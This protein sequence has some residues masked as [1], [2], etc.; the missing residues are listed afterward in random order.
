MADLY[1]ERLLD[2]LRRAEEH[3][4]SALWGGWTDKVPRLQANVDRL[5]ALIQ[6]HLSPT[7]P[8]PERQQ[9]GAK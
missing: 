8:P 2:D 4:R 9:E 1:E 5:H 6:K 7:E 3:L